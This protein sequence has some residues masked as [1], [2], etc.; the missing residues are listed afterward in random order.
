MDSLFHI[1]TDIECRVLHYGK[2]VCIVSPGEDGTILLRKGRHKLT[3]IS[4]ENPADQL[5]IV[6]EVPE[7]DIEDYIEV[8]LLPIRDERLAREAEEREKAYE[9][10]LQ[11]K[12]KEKEQK[13]LEVQ[14]RLEEERE[15]RRKAEEEERLRIEKAKEA[16]WKQIML[17]FVPI[18]REAKSYDEKYRA[19]WKA[20]YTLFPRRFKNGKIGFI[21]HKGETIIQPRFRLKPNTPNV[22]GF[23]E[24]LSCAIEEY[25]PIAAVTFDGGYKLGF[26]AKVAFINSDGKIALSSNYF[27]PRTMLNYQR[28]PILYPF[29][30]QDRVIVQQREN[31]GTKQFVLKKGFSNDE[32]N[33]FVKNPSPAIVLEK[34]SSEDGE[35][36]IECL[37]EMPVYTDPKY[38]LIDKQGIIHREI[39]P[40]PGYTPL[41]NPFSQGLSVILWFNKHSIIDVVE[42][43]DREGNIV[44]TYDTSSDVKLGKLDKSCFEWPRYRDPTVFLGESAFFPVAKVNPNRDDYRMYLQINLDG[45]YSVE[46]LYRDTTSNQFESVMSSLK[47]L[48]IKDSYAGLIK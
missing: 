36:V 16:E 42:V 19:F 32:W 24:G 45:T 38:I 28:T 31:N 15:K 20:D 39:A 13:E 4:K 8:R 47:F 33:N 10:E 29:F 5:T 22:Y 44:I 7:N 48:G 12:L 46:E 14:R 9:A 40:K 25:I 27:L 6:Y 1:D 37:V 21:N 43:I 34:K 18:F 23:Y 41:F 17:P 26:D 2:E 35:N 3:F 11:R 30:S